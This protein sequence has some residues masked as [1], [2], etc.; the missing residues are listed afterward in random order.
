M[1]STSGWRIISREEPDISRVLFSKCNALKG[2]LSIW[3]ICYQIP[4]AAL[5]G[6]SRLPPSHRTGKRPTLVP[7][8][9]SQPGFTEPAPLDAAGALLPHLCTLTEEKVLSLSWAVSFCGTILTIARTGRYPAG[10]V[11]REPGLS[12]DG[13]RFHRP[14]LPAL[15]LLLFQFSWRWL[16]SFS[17]VPGQSGSP[18]EFG[19]GEVAEDASP[20][21]RW[22]SLWPFKPHC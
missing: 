6:G 1:V 12:S 5:Y 22:R 16:G 2:Q 11:F 10:L 4:Q 18:V 14:Q 8:P 15:T 19:E 20:I 3:D 21:A 9:C 7:W 17:G 13:W